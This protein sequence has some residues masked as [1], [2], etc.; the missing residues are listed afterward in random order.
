MSDG[1][2]FMSGR[3]KVIPFERH[4]SDDE[5]DKQLKQL[6]RRRENKSAI[7]NWLVLGRRLMLETGFEPSQRVIEAIEDYRREADVI[8][9]FLCERTA[10]QDGKRLPASDLYAAYVLWAKDNGYQQ[11]NK[12]GFV[13]ELR[14][15]S[16][17]K[18]GNAGQ[19][20]IGVVLNNV[21]NRFT[22]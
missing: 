7:L 8:G 6:F 10:S 22:E 4:F 9:R 20:V 11:I 12:N 2:V 14:S 16:L 3:A 18:R 15:R 1:T 13:A 17:I 19:M 5:Q 21:Q